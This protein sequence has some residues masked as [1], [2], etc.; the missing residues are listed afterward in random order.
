MKF[1]QAPALLSTD[2]PSDSPAK[3]IDSP[4]NGAKRRVHNQPVTR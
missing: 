3:L 1:P 2:A 4:A